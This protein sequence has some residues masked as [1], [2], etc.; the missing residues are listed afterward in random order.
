[1][2]YSVQ[3]NGKI[4]F[5]YKSMKKANEIWDVISKVVPD[6]EVSIIVEREANEK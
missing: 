2:K 3:F 5:S 1:M 6:A 4:M